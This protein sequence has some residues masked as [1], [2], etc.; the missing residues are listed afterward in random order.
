M[1]LIRIF[2]RLRPGEEF[3]LSCSNPPHAIISWRGK[4]KIPTNEE[5]EACWKVLQDEDSQLKPELSTEDRLS[6]LEGEVFK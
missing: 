5:L 4:S 3:L 6:R 1:D 2:A